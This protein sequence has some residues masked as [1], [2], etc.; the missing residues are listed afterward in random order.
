VEVSF[1]AVNRLKPSD[2]HAKGIHLR[3]FSRGRKV[4][5]L[6]PMEPKFVQLPASQLIQVSDLLVFAPADEVTQPRAM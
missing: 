3:L 5:L 4:T 1:H 2:E 6:T